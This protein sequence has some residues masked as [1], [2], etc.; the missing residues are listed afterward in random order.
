MNRKTNQLSFAWLFVLLSIYTLPLPAQSKK[1][2]PINTKAPYLP[3]CFALYIEDRKDH[4][5]VNWNGKALE[6]FTFPVHFGIIIPDVKEVTPSPQAWKQFW[7][8]MEAVHLWQWL[9]EKPG[10]FNGSE[11]WADD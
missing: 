7:Q 10:P 1:N 5:E 2:S 11:R 4:Y 9:Q 6:Y 3:K 8:E